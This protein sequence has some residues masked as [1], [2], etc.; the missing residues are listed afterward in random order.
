[1]PAIWILLSHLLAALELVLIIILVAMCHWASRMTG[2]PKVYLMPMP[3]P[4]LYGVVG[5]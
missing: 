2:L 5:M 4:L 3:M 1:M